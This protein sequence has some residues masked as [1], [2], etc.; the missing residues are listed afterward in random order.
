M[1]IFIRVIASRKINKAAGMNML[2]RAAKI[3]GT[4]PLIKYL[5]LSVVFV[6]GFQNAF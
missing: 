6:K 4:T 3:A 1:W 5:F 2:M